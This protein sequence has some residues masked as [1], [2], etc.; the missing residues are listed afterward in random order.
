MKF[1]YKGNLR[2]RGAYF[3]MQLQTSSIGKPSQEL[4]T[5]NHITSTVQSR[6]INTFSLAC[7]SLACCSLACCSL[8]CCLLLACLCSGVLLHFHT[9]QKMMPPTGVRVFPHQLIK[10]I[11]YKQVHRLALIDSPSLRHCPGDSELCRVDN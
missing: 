9:G 5:S 10:T 1:P 2:K 11:P 4:E 7:C 3:T 6:E 8:A